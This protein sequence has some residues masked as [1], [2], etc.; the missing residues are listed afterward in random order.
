MKKV[1]Q[2]DE[3]LHYAKQLDEAI[4][5]EHH[6]VPEDLW[7]LTKPHMTGDLSRFCTSEILS[8][9]LSVDPTFNF[10]KS[11][12]TPFTYKHLLLKSKRTGLPP[13][14]LGPTA[15][16]Y[17]KEKSVYSKIVQAVASKTP[18]GDS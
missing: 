17:S 15:I 2:V 18:E 13:V 8:H 12:V 4:V 1:D 10:G 3:L 16:H 7:V 5:I 14:F 6:D 9:P 11:E